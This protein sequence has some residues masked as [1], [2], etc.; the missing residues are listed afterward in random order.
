MPDLPLN[1]NQAAL[2]LEEDEEGE[3]SVQ[4]VQSSQADQV[5]MPAELC[6]VIA[7]K[8]IDR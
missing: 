1:K 7:C 4:V 2:L 8:K 5:N 3:I 6:Q